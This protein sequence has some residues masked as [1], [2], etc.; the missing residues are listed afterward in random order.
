MRSTQV[1]S[2][3]G[4]FVESG[5]DDSEVVGGRV[6]LHWIGRISTRAWMLLHPGGALHNERGRWLA[7]A[8]AVLDITESVWLRRGMF[9]GPRGQVRRSA[10]DALDAAVGEATIT[11]MWPPGGGSQVLALPLATETA[12]RFGVRRAATLVTPATLVVAGVRALR[13]RPFQLSDILL[14]PSLQIGAGKLFAMTERAQIRRRSDHELQR[15]QAAGEQRALAGER[16]W[17]SANLELL[18][19]LEPFSLSIRHVPGVE[20][21]RAQDEDSA[22]KTI[23]QVSLPE[24]GRRAYLAALLYRFE[25]HCSTTHRIEERLTVATLAAADQQ[26]LLTGHQSRLLWDAL[27]LKGVAGRL[28]VRVSQNTSRGLDSEV[29][30]DI[31][32]SRTVDN[33][34]T[35]RFSVRLPT[36]LPAWRV[37]FVTVGLLLAGAYPPI[38]CLPG[39]GTTIPWRIGLLTMGLDWAAAA[40]AEWSVRRLGSEAAPPAAMAGIVPNGLA[41]T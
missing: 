17:V 14:W 5:G 38:L 11:S 22:A 25:D 36:G 2:R 32:S 41:L 21:A 15:R 33:G 6:A 30:L 8:A 26:I 1:V 34:P 23:R 24:P 37:E 20:L 19:R 3:C 27:A 7:G 31:V 28:H 10:L 9:D 18:D 29:V 35:T 39:G 4:L 16:A 40:T 12:Y 13:S